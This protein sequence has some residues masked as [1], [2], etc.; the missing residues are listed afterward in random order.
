MQAAIWGN[1][2]S[3]N[4]AE[5]VEKLLSSYHALRCKAPLKFHFLQSHLYIFPGNKGAVSD[6]HDERFH[7]DI[8]RMKK[9]Y[10][11]K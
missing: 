7:Q 2:K 8:F 6:E 1:K 10:G 9:R 5:I 3:E 4:Y 11:C